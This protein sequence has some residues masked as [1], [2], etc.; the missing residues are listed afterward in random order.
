MD[1]TVKSVLGWVEHDADMAGPDDQI[2]GL[3]S[4]NTP[5]ILA[6]GVKIEGA[7]I[8][9]VDARKEVDLMHKVGAIKLTSRLLLIVPRGVD[10]RQSFF[11]GQQPR[12]GGSLPRRG[13]DADRGKHNRT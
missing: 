3:G 12:G 5:K 10:N 8:G 6:P 4:L 9:V 1:R 7:R 13:P 11:R 2:A